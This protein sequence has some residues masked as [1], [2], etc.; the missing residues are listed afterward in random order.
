MMVY[1][2]NHGKLRRRIGAADADRAASSHWPLAAKRAQRFAI[3]NPACGAAIIANVSSRGALKIGQLCVERAMEGRPR[4]AAIK[5]GCEPT[6]ACD[7][8]GM[9]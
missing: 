7:D 4:G 3:P 1:H 2:C 6:V 5:V 8:V 9:V